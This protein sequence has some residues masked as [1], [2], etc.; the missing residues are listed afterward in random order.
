[1]IPVAEALG[2]QHPIRIDEGDGETWHVLLGHEL[3]NPLAVAR[4]D[5]RHRVGG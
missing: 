4:D 2:P 1:M 5:G 3:G